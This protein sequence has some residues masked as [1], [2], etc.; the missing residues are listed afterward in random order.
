M[1]ALLRSLF[2]SIVRPLHH[3]LQVEEPMYAG[4]APV[5]TTLLAISF[6]CI[7]WMLVVKPV[8]LYYRKQTRESDTHEM[9]RTSEHNFNT[10]VGR[11]TISPLLDKNTDH[12]DYRLD[13]EKEEVAAGGIGTDED[14]EEED[15]GNGMGEICIHQ[16]IE[17]IEFVLGM[18]SCYVLG[19]KKL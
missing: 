14:E 17:T 3:L 19:V 12:P 6:V 4:Q 5:Q 2:L 1:C 11:A 15:V 10:S 18:V 8:V 7:P 13:T 9:L 16:A